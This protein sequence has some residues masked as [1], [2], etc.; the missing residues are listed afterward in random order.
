MMRALL[1][2]RPRLAR[3]AAD[4]SGTSVI[5]L[6]MVAPVLSLLTMGIVDISNGYGRRLEL[7]QAVNRTAELVAAGEF[8]IPENADG[9]PD[10]TA[11]KADAAAAAG[12]ETSQVE[13]IRWLECDGVEQTEY[14]SLCEPED[15][16]ACDTETPPDDCDPIIARYVQIRIDDSFR[17]MFG[18]I[19]SRRADGSFPLWAEA[20]VRVQ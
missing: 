12:V 4:E 1:R 2:L 16:A 6:A 14:E 8:K 7:V 13:V 10:Y 9:T 15:P 5:E 3:I 11:L 18:T 20:A 19:F 17:P